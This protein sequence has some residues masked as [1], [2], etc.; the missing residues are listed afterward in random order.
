M[1]S[2]KVTLRNAGDYYLETSTN[3]KVWK[4][5]SVRVETGKPILAYNT[6]DIPNSLVE[7]IVANFLAIGVFDANGLGNANNSALS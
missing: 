5:A 1:R 2:I 3:G 6:T 4:A 7:I